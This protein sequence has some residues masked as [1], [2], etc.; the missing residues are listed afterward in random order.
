MES[1]NGT[2][3]NLQPYHGATNVL[4]REYSS[5]MT[6]YSAS[7]IPRKMPPKSCLDV[8]KDPYTA[9]HLLNNAEQLLFISYLFSILFC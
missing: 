9:Q 3:R 6:H 5:K 8:C 7:Y 2:P 4:L 1:G